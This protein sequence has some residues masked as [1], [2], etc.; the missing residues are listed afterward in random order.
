MLQKQL[1]SVSNQVMKLCTP[2][3][4]YLLISVLSIVVI[5]LQNVFDKTKYCLGNYSCSLDYSNYFIFL[6]K[7]VYV[8]VFTV[9]LDSLCKNKYNK[10]AWAL[11]LLPYVLMFFFI[12]N[13]IKM[14][15]F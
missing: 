4:V 1:K 10:L 13:F 5:L 7:F 6:V 11:L 8:G 3:R 2:S 15:R 14:N 12:F 9:I